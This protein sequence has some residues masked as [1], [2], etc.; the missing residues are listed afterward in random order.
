MKSL[1]VTMVC[2]PALGAILAG[3]GK[4]YAEPVQLPVEE[5]AATTK[6]DLG[7]GGGRAGGGFLPPE[8]D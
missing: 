2:I 4:D 7:Q 6:T 1:L 5:S 3:C 8:V